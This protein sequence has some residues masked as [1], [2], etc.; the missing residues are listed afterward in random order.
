MK[1]IPETENINEEFY[2]QD[3]FGS[4]VDLDLSFSEDKSDMVGPK[5]K[6]DF[7]IFSLTDAVAS[8]NK[9]EAWVLYQRA[10]ASGMAAEEIFWKIVWQVKTLLVANQTKSADEAGMKAYPYSKAKGSLRNFK[11]GEV[12][13]ISESLVI[14]YHMARRGEGD[15]ELLIEKTILGL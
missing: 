4:V 7:N 15:V 1:K 12:E 13:K 9:R 5:S 14:G 10:L 3:L 8:R 6:S 11:P 2:H